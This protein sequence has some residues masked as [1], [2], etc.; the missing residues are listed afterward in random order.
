MARRLVD[1]L[2][3]R[4][5]EGPPLALAW[6]KV[7]INV[8]LKQLVMGGFETSIAYDMLSLTTNDVTEGSQ[9][10][11]EKRKPRFTGT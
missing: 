1:D 10:F 3:V 6:T 5:A 2:A 8:M 7:A 11:I 9:A 4:L